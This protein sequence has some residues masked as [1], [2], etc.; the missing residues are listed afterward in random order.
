MSCFCFIAIA[1]VTDPGPDAPG[2]V[3]TPNSHFLSITVICARDP[4]QMRP[5][6][7]RR[8]L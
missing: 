1:T 3:S 8:S 7:S 6:Y 4:A 2:N 5:I